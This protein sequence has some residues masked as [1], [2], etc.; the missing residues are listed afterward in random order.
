MRMRVEDWWWKR[1]GGADGRWIGCGCLWTRICGLVA[2]GLQGQE[3]QPELKDIVK[4]FALRGLGVLPG[5]TP[6]LVSPPIETR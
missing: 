1:R 6:T 2:Q 3:S 5:Y 4:R